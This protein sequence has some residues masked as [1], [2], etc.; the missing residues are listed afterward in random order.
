MS[1]KPGVQ[2][3]RKSRA[4]RLLRLILATFD[5]RAWAHFIKVMNFYNYNH[6]QEIRK[7]QVSRTANIAPNSGFA[8]GQNV[9]IGEN[10]TIGAYCQIWAGPEKAR[11][12]IGRDALFAPDVMVTATSYRYDEGAPVTD[13]AMD[14]ADIEIGAD[15]WI[16]R[17]ATILAGTTLG[18]GCIVG[19]HAVV[20]GH[21]PPYS[22][23]VGMPARIVGQRKRF[24]A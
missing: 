12:V 24:G 19:A 17:G 5:P 2:K 8:N 3:V 7:A 6:L 16:G 20:R 4:Q 22:I 15:C 9:V 18:E 21:F 11:V 14:E 10:V 13:Q 23:L 1:K